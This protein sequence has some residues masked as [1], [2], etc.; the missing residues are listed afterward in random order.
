MCVGVDELS[1]QIEELEETYH[2]QMQHFPQ[3]FGHHDMH[4]MN[5]I[6]NEK[7]GANLTETE[8]YDGR[9]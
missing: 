7:K 2:K 3:V 9:L 5:I 6:F 1:R 8:G 4:H